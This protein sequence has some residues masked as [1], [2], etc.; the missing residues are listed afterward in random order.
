MP[1]REQ[2]PEA[3]ELVQLPRP[4]WAPAFLALGIAIAVNGIYGEGFMFRGWTYMIIGGAIAL[5]ALR[6]LAVAAG[7][8]YFRL[9]REQ[10]PR[11]AVLPAASVKPP[12]RQG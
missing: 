2:I 9:P 4:S 7:R 10:Q 3:T 8:E 6:S 12:S 11:S 5:L 1:E